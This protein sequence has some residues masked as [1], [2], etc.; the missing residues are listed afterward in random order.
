MPVSSGLD[1]HLPLDAAYTAILLIAVLLITYIPWLSLGLL[2][3][4]ERHGYLVR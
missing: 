1:P 4:L 3:V 2:G